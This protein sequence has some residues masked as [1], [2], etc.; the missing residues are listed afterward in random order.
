VLGRA[1]IAPAGNPPFR[2]EIAYDDAAVHARGR[3]A[4]RATVK[5]GEHLLF[6][7][8]RAYPVFTG[9]DAPLSLMLVSARAAPRA[10][11]T[12]M[13]SYMADAAIITLCADGR[14]LPVAMEADYKYSRL[15]T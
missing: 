5:H 8:S 13:F 11:L 4:V 9:N 10:A 2:F 12:G 7:T 1:G 3:Y 14:K 15:H 6:T